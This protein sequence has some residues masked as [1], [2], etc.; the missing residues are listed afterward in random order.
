MTDHTCIQFVDD[1]DPDTFYGP[2]IYDLAIPNVGE[3]VSVS[4]SR[5][6]DGN[7]VSPDGRINRVCVSGIVTKREFRYEETGKSAKSNCVTCFVMLY[8]HKTCDAR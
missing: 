1:A 5:D 3:Y 7:Y 4:T 6:D 2:N 8:I